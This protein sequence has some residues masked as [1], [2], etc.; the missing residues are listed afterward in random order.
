[1][2]ASGDTYAV[3]GFT[4]EI[5]TPSDAFVT[6]ASFTPPTNSAGDWSVTLLGLDVT[7]APPVPGNF[8]RAD[9]TFSHVR[10]AGAPTLYPATPAATNVVSNGTGS[11]YAVQVVLS[12]NIIEIQ[13]AGNAATD[14]DWSV[15]GQLQAVT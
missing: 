5:Q 14:V 6:I 9:V 11:T 15:I 13:V 12:G 4:G 1:V 7:G 2:L 10:A 8:Y 3:K